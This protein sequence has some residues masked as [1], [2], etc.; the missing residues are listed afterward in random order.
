MW[1]SPSL[2]NDREQDFLVYR[3][4]W[5]KRF[6]DKYVDTPVPSN[7]SNLKDPEGPNIGSL[8]K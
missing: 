4:Y 2:S 1:L 6:Y 7:P 5:S 3:T 8:K